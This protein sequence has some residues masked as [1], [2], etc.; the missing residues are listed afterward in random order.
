MRKNTGQS[1]NSVKNVDD[2]YDIIQR[3]FRDTDL[4]LL[5]WTKLVS[6]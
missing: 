4:E 2:I 1:R 6:E 5:L 3:T